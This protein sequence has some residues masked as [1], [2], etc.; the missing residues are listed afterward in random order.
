MPTEIVQGGITQKQRYSATYYYVIHTFAHW[1]QK[2]ENLDHKTELPSG[3]IQCSIS[4]VFGM[5]WSTCCLKQLSFNLV[6]HGLVVFEFIKL[7]LHT[8]LRDFLGFKNFYKDAVEWKI[9]HLRMVLITMC[10]VNAVLKLANNCTPLIKEHSY[11]SILIQIFI[12]VF[13]CEITLASCWCFLSLARLNLSLVVNEMLLQCLC[14]T[15]HKHFKK[16]QHLLSFNKKKNS[17]I[18][19]F[20][21]HFKWH[22]IGHWDF[23]LIEKCPQISLMSETEGVWHLQKY[24]IAAVVQNKS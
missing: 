3:Q 8:G 20:Q 6:E 9:W 21:L 5:K 14:T 7:K 18:L 24:S 15:V 11:W 13:D 4:D 19:L 1:Q 10:S 16:K 12:P 22:L 17:A 23:I 2:E